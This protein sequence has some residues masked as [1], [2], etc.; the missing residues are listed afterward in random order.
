LD[1]AERMVIK[2]GCAFLDYAESG[3]AKEWF[4][5]QG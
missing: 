5:R 2:Q 3:S 1:L 4:L